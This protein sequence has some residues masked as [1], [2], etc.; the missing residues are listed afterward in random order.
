MT[1]EALSGLSALLQNVELGF[2]KVPLHTV[3]LKSDFVSGHVTFGATPEFPV[4]RFFFSHS[5]I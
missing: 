5:G 4:Q 3:Y 1:E 2:V